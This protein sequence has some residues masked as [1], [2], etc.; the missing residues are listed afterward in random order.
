[1]DAHGGMIQQTGIARLNDPRWL[2][3][4]LIGSNLKYPGSACDYDWSAAV[5]FMTP[6]RDICSDQGS[7]NGVWRWAIGELNVYS[8][9]SAGGCAGARS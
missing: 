3:L 6:P 5:G 1:M 8:N 2:Q 9:S 4:A 7:T